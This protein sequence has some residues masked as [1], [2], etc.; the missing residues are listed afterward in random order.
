MGM[1]I[2]LNGDDTSL[3]G[4]LTLSADFAGSLI[5]GDVRG[6]SDA[7]EHYYP[8]TLLISAGAIYR[9]ADTAIDY[10]FTADM[11]GTLQAPGGDLAVDG[12]IDG[13]FLGASHQ[14]VSGAVLG[15]VTGAG[16]IGII[17]GDF[18]AQQ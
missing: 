12:I 11:N 6:V 4:T 16:S 7:G 9:G 13:D 14:A 15:T 5:S 1:T 3:A 10:T 2:T 18:L 17:F 8:G